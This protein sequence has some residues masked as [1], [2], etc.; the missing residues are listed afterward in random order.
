MPI[1]T[2]EE[3]KELLQVTV[4]TY[5]DSIDAQIPIITDFIHNFTK[6]RFAWY[7]VYLTSTGIAFVK[8]SPDTITDE[9]AGFVEAGF[10]DGMDIWVNNSLNSDCARYAETVTAGTL[11]LSSDNELIDENSERSIT[12]YR[13]KYPVSLKMT[14]SKM[15]AFNLD[16][17]NLKGVKSK[18]I[19]DLSYSFAGDGNYPSD[20]LAELGAFRRTRWN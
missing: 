6:N 12:I 8:G 4:S 16:R 1:A 9:G 7:S 10:A 11:T 3:V 20:L 2:T 19:G 13:V 18:S 17:S 14:L 5:D 15:I